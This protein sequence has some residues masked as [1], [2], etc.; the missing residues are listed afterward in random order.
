MAKNRNDRKDQRRRDAV[1]R[2]S[3]IDCMSSA[4]R[5]EAL[6]DR[7]GVDVGAVKERERLAKKDD[8]G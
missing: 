8:N 4:E 5:I 7:L 2:Q 1:E 3:A 6:D